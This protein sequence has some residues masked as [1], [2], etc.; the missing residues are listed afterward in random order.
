MKAAA[1]LPLLAFAWGQSNPACELPGSLQPVAEGPLQA[2]EWQAVRHRLP[3]QKDAKWLLARVEIGGDF[4]WAV[5]D[6]G[7][8]VP[9]MIDESL[10]DRLDLSARGGRLLQDWL[11]QAVYREGVRLPDW[12]WGT[13]SQS[14]TRALVSDLDFLRTETGKPVQL[15]LGYGLFRDGLV[16]IDAAARE[17]RLLDGR[18][19][20]PTASNQVVPLW[21]WAGVP[22]CRLTVGN[23]RLRMMI[24]SGFDGGLALP[25]AQRTSL[26]LRGEAR[27]L[28]VVRTALGSGGEVYGARL[29][30]DL[31]WAGYRFPAPGV[32]FLQGYRHAVLGRSALQSLVL[33]FEPKAD[34]MHVGLPKKNATPWPWPSSGRKAGILNSPSAATDPAAPVDKS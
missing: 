22:L 24:D 11:G 25:D 13:W 26:K 8:S 23:Q 34:R 20:E 28:G 15:V 1:I 7:L 5:Y 3:L 27:R 10:A 12:K 30:E 17:I 33:T 18:L 9:A 16:Q 14:G 4:V 2:I 31:S 29:N 19:P 21:R 32:Q 6:T